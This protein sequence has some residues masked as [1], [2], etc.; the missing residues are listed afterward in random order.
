LQSLI[1]VWNLPEVS[2][3]SCIFLTFSNI[4]L[5]YMARFDV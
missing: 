5:A 3:Y 1:A 4:L 2:S